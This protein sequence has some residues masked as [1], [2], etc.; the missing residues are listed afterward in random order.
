MPAFPV[1]RQ[2]SSGG[3]GFFLSRRGYFH[4]LSRCSNLVG[5][6]R[7]YGVLSREFKKSPYT[8]PMMRIDTETFFSQIGSRIAQA[9]KDATLSQEQLASSLGLKQ[10]ALA[11]YETGRRRIPL[12]TLL[13]IADALHVTIDDL[14]PS[15][16]SAPSR[17]R[18][19]VPKIVKQWEKLRTLPDEKQKIV[20]DLIDSW[21]AE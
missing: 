4:T 14:L 10:Q 12:P 17:K 21:A 8:F 2:D 13:R 3:A 9:R 20:F 1:I 5:L 15:Q 19:P 6:L 18:G 7:Q 16:N 11:S